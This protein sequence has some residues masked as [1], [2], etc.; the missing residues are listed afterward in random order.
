M[1]NF[2]EKLAINSRLSDAPLFG[3]HSLRDR[4]I[5]KF[6]EGSLQV[7]VDSTFQG[8]QSIPTAVEYLLGGQNCGKV[9]VR[10]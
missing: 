4:L 1:A 9:I 3:M 8:L 7:I 6:L 2:S 5:D 10:L